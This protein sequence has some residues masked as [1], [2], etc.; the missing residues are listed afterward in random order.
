MGTNICVGNNYALTYLSFNDYT[1][2]LYATLD[3]MNTVMQF[4]PRMS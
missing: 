3:L 4:E 2:S 1:S